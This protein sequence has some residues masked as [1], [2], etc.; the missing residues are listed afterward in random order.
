MA[1]VSVKLVGIGPRWN[2]PCQQAANPLNQLFKR[3]AI[4]IV[5]VIG[6]SQGP[7]IS[8]MNDSSIQGNAVHGR[9]SARTDAAGKL[10]QADVSLPDNVTINTP[11]GIRDAGPGVLEV[12][13]AHEYVHALGHADHN[14][15]LMGQTMYKVMGDT[16]AGDKL[17]SGN[18]NMP[19][20]T[21]S[22]ESVSI[23][24]GI[25]N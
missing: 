23:L 10:L 11:Q 6:G 13:V 5:L 8:V 24:K 12:I 15:Q 25:W 18:V 9:T 4:K 2:K 16:A 21:L 1:T 19:N 7:I 3:H 17:K 14:S 20:L 22:Q